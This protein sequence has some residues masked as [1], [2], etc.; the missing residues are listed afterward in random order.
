[1]THIV[2]VTGVDLP[3][4]PRA[5]TRLVYDGATGLHFLVV[6]VTNPWRT[7]PFSMVYP[8]DRHG[9]LSSIP[10][11][12]EGLPLLACGGNYDS[13][14][15]MLEL[16]R[17]LETNTLLD[18]TASNEVYLGLIDEDTEAF[19]RYITPRHAE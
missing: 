12:K 9:R 4:W 16:T 14:G 6:Q 13:E 15:A 10:G 2:A 11:W 7:G 1:M 8:T 18:R 5:E 19:K 17:R 3:H